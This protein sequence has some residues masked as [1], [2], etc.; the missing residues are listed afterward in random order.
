M[1]VTK[2]ILLRRAAVVQRYKRGDT[3][4]T[5]IAR[6][7][8][9]HRPFVYRTIRRFKETGDVKD[10]P[11]PGR[12]QKYDM[13]RLRGI[14]RNKKT[15]SSRKAARKL[16]REL[17]Q[18]VSH[19]TVLRAAK[20]KKMVYRVRPKKSKLTPRHRDSRLAFALK[21][22]ERDFWKQVVAVDETSM[23]LYSEVRGI[24]LDEGEE[25][26]PRET[27]KWPAR[28]KVWAG[29]S[30]NGKTRLHFIPKIMT[31]LDYKDFLDREA[32]DD[33]FNL[34]PNPKHPGILLEDGEG[35]HTAK[36]VQKFLANSPIRNI[37]NYPS[38]S[39]D[40]NWQENVWEMMLQRVRRRCPQTIEGLKKAMQEAW[41]DITL[42]EI[43]SCVKSMT[44]RLSAVIAT[45]GGYTRY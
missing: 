32:M 34:Y 16:S 44:S 6:A 42:D 27:V 41:E 39:P 18:S 37:K 25:V 3:S 22:R 43:R 2:E 24:W 30:W 14:L 10:R 23:E 12:P 13:S 31:G 28:L 40:L 45:N 9:E 8:G 20:K 1:T 11:R 4:V 5:S 36:N 38:R 33:F 35:F 19:Q 17:G 15:G 29:T 26:P 21:Q 7:L